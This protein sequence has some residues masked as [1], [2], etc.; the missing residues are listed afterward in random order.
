MSGSFRSASDW[1]RNLNLLFGAIRLWQT[2]SCFSSQ[3]ASNHVPEVVLIAAHEVMVLPLLSGWLSFQFVKVAGLWS[4]QWD[5][6]FLWR[7]IQK[8]RDRSGWIFSFSVKFLNLARSVYLDLQLFLAWCH[9][10]KSFTKMY[11]DVFSVE[12]KQ[13]IWS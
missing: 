10:I 7:P 9:V 2:N 13:R 6:R 4:D 1:K 5:Q 3:S 11:S 12:K 8:F